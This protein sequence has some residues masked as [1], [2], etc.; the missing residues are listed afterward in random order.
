MLLRKEAQAEL[1]EKLRLR[2]ERLGPA[3]AGSPMIRSAAS[4]SEPLG[5]PMPSS[6]TSLLETNSETHDTTT[7]EHQQS[8]Q[9]PIE[10]VDYRYQHLPG[11]DPNAVLAQADPSVDAASAGE[12][13]P[14]D[15][16]DSAD[17]Q[18]DAAGQ[19][20]IDSNEVDP[21]VGAIAAA[22]QGWNLVDV[23]EQEEQ[24]APDVDYNSDGEIVQEL[25]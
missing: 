16:V 9:Q 14:H 23:Q 21:E 22:W 5:G 11:S 8:Q 4:L 18:R 10:S 20:Q 2:R 24:V 25:D 19:M 1:E 7:T 13:N 15:G 6:S 17:K 3:R 12:A